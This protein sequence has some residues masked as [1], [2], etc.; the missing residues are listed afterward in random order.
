MNS[1]DCE[2]LTCMEQAE[3]NTLST[4][5]RL[6]LSLTTDMKRLVSVIKG[7]AKNL[8]KHGELYCPCSFIKDESTI[9]PCV[10]LRTE[11]TCHCNLFHTE[12][13]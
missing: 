6:K 4:S 11:G 2:P 7:L 1:V 9:C 3:Y 12:E 8:E 5:Y 10:E 13:N